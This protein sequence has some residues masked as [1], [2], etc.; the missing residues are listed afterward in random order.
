[1]ELMLMH[2]TRQK[3]LRVPIGYS[4]TM[5]FFGPLVPLFRGDI[6]YAL[7]TFF[8]SYIS[9][10]L[11]RLI[12]PFIYNRMYIERLLKKGY[13]PVSDNCE[14]VLVENGFDFDWNN[15]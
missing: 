14:K 10:G 11:S 1:M 5:L 12:F 4:W 8:L 7:I 2:E 13:F 9:N 6:K 3:L 15:V